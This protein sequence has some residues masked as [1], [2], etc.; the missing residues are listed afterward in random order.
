MSL[1]QVERLLHEAIGLDPAAVGRPVIERAVQRRQAQ[2]AL[3]DAA[4]YV[5]R[6]QHSRRELQALVETVVVPETWFFREPAAF[7]ALARY[8][9]EEW[10]PAHPAGKLRV[11]S[12][13][14]STGEEPYSLAMTLLDAGVPAGRFSVDAVDVSAQA[15]AVARHAVYGKHSFRSGDLEFRDRHLQPATLGFEV[16]PAVRA[17]VRFHAG[18]L[19]DLAVPGGPALQPVSREPAWQPA[20]PYDVI[21]CRHLLIYFDR[22]TQHRLVQWLVALLATD[23]LLFVGPSEAG[24]LPEHGLV[25]TRWRRSF[26]FRH[27]VTPAPSAAPRRKGH[28]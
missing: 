26:A 2:C 19:H 20:P 21:F 17:G 23:G 10:L 1:A 7:V 4:A 11:L 22:P 3:P 6:V 28:A 14:C 16:K 18:N 5:K 27:R 15:L 8:V 24:L 9:R 12:A 25:Y 13:P